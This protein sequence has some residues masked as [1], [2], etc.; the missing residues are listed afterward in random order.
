MKEYV[1]PSG[2]VILSTA[3]LQG[4]IVSYNTGFKDA[5]GYS[6]AELKGKPHSLLRHPDMPKEAFADMWNTL[7]A[8]L[9]WFGII[10]NKRKNDEYYWVSANAA[11]LIDNGRV[12]GY[13]S[14]RYPATREQISA[15]Q[16]LYAEVKAGRKTLP[17]TL[18]AGKTNQ[19]LSGV[20]LGSGVLSLGVLASGLFASPLV[21][22][23]SALVGIAGLG[24]L[25]KQAFSKDQL[26][27]Q[28]KK[29][30]E[31]ICNGRYSTPITDNSSLGFELNLIRS[32]V[33]ERAAHNYDAARESRMMTKALDSA[34]S[35]IMIADAEFTILSMN[36]TLK[37]FFRERETL[38]RQALPQF[39]AERIIGSK[40]DIFHKNPAHQRQLLATM[41]KTVQSD[42][43]LSG[44]V[45]RLTVI[46]IM[47]E[48][49]HLGYVVE[50]LDRTVEATVIAELAEVFT[51]VKEGDF[52]HRIR[53]NAEGI[54]QEIKQDVNAAMETIQS[55]LDAI[56]E[57]I[58]AQA[59]GDLTKALPAGIFRGQLH[60]LKNAINYSSTKVKDSVSQA[61]TTSNVVSSA[62]NQVS[63]GASDLSGRVQEQAASLEETSA[64]M[65]QISAAVE[66]NTTNA[67]KVS[68]LANN[69]QGQASAGVDVMQKTIA[70]MQS[71][72]DSSTKIAD[73]VTII[74]GIAFQTN[75]LALNAAVEAARAGEHGRGFAVV[76][77]EVRAL[78]QKS[79][80]AAKDIK[81]L[82]TDSVR[83][84]ETGT[85]LADKS[86]EML[87]G[88]TESIAHVAGMVEQIANASSEQA[89]GIQ[90]VHKAIAD[91]DRITQENSALVE[92]TTAAAESLTVEANNLQENMSFFNT[93]VSNIAPSPRTPKTGR[94]PST[95]LPAPKANSNE[96]SSF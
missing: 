38:L 14:V 81:H 31:D 39:S 43:K 89:I 59:Q 24:Y 33:A 49:T 27:P 37:S 82:I 45:L 93:G 84:I 61:I 86:G 25:A 63:Q 77:G 83:R 44:L 51:N 72:K 60:D 2:L 57:V 70:A 17:R 54:Y 55:A 12:T 92:E 35:N 48:G 53:A 10:K 64:T 5:S 16:S 91:I 46:P 75:L 8:G 22:G 52:T 88:I 41:T 6:D 1:I 56:N 78:A 94:K 76:A 32:R 65:N 90:Q 28:L 13:V 68:E 80:S 50:W 40:M 30:V 47:M 74:D 21:L 95:G 15:T 73:I 96:W 71:I 62:A 3:D 11:P 34:S 4:N 85:H 18:S 19:L 9:P 42:I 79:A 7:K 23:L 69:V 67:K 36:K 87:N 66:T 26:S 58:A 20:A 29:G